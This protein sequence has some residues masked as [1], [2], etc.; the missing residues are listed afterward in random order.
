[1]KTERKILAATLIGVLFG[2][3]WPLGVLF[4]GAWLLTALLFRY[5][6]LAALVATLLQPLLAMILG[7]DRLVLPLTILVVVIWFMHR[8][9]IMRLLTH[10]ESK[11]SFAKKL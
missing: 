5:S 4:L 10:N 2:L 8:A 6:S 1:M 7:L 11:I 9:N 3:Y